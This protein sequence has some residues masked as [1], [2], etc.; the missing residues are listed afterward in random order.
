MLRSQKPPENLWPNRL[1]GDAALP[2]E[3]RVAWTTWNPFPPDTLLLES[4]LLEP[5]RLLVTSEKSP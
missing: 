5:V 2:Q 4:G 3:Q 1:I